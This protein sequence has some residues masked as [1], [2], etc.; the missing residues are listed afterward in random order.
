MIDAKKREEVRALLLLG[1]MSY[2]AI[3]RQVGV[4]DATVRKMVK[5][6]GIH[7]VG[8]SAQ[9]PHCNDGKTVQDVVVSR[10][11]EHKL[12]FA[13]MAWESIFEALELG[14]RRVRRALEQEAE[15]DKMI[16][17]IQEDK[18]LHP[19]TKQSL[20][21]KVMALQIQGI[22][23]ISTYVGTLYDKQ[24][25]ASGEPTSKVQ[26]EVSGQVT[27][28]YEYEITQKIINDP[29]ARDAARE[30]FRRAVGRDLAG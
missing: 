15:L 18:D 3:G 29:D 21:A 27:Q 1:T 30:L 8:E 10:H 22:R 5:E 23:D 26:Q 20:I 17:I 28:R 14:Q 12:Q 16:E 19:K 4:S 25:L 24:A 9:V 6:L 7:P 2:R 13:D 11:L